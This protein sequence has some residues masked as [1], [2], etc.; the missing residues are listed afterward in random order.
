MSDLWPR[1]ALTKLLHLDFP[2]LQGPLTGRFSPDLIT[3]FCYAGGLGLL[4]ASYMS[5]EEIRKAIDLVRMKTR[6]Q[7]NVHLY[8]IHNA[9]HMDRALEAQIALNPYRKKLGIPELSTLPAMPCTFEQQFQ[10]ILDERVPVFSFS[11]GLLR[12]DQMKALKNNKTF[13]IG[14]ATNLAEIKELE[15]IG[16]DAIVLQGEESGG[17]RAT[18][19]GSVTDSLLSLLT[20]IPLAK[21]ITRLPLIA[22]G[23]ITSAAQIIAAL[24]LGAEGIQLGTAFAFCAESTIPACY[25]KAL[26][27]FSSRPTVI[28]SAYS[29]RPARVIYTHFLDQ[30]EKLPRTD[31]PYQYIL[32]Q[33]LRDKCQQLSNIDFLPLFAGESFSQASD[34]SALEIFYELAQCTSQQLKELKQK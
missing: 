11:C 32:M 29:G 3:S 6:K 2:L 20:F 24:F 27:K 9:I 10:V 8:C 28:T 18:F 33:D 13:V 19:I 30:L 34:R 26:K 16:V 4:E 21:E 1:N 25:K 15:Q 31:F 5:T 12:Q 17:H 14:T 7:F 23:G 22:S